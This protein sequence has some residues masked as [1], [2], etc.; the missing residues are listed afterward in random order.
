MKRVVRAGKKK[1]KTDDRRDQMDY[2][3]RSDMR[4]RRSVVEEPKS[5]EERK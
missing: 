4:A 3:E 5:W 1:N 2:G